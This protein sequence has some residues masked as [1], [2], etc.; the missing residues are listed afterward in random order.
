MINLLFVFL[1]SISY[2]SQ[3]VCSQGPPGIPGLD[4]VDGDKGQIGKQGPTVSDLYTQS[5]HLHKIEVK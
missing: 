3:C 4:G 1:Q 5:V 2:L